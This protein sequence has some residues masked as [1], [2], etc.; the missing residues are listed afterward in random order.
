MAREECGLFLLAWRDGGDPLVDRSD[1]GF[2]DEPNLGFHA[3]R[4]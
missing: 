3:M 1:E 4:P 2:G